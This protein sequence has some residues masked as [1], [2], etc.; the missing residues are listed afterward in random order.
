[1]VRCHEVP[2]SAIRG[3]STPG[4]VFGA[5]LRRID[6]AGGMSPI[7]IFSPGLADVVGMIERSR[8]DLTFRTSWYDRLAWRF[9][10]RTLAWRRL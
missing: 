1:M 4:S 3:M 9:G 6:V 5:G 8:P 10:K 7:L 2:T